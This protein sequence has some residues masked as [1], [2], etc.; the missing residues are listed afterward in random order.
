MAQDRGQ[1]L[2]QAAGA[3]GGMADTRAV[4]AEAI[5]HRRAA[6]VG[7]PLR[8]PGYGPR[9]DQV[10]P[11]QLLGDE[12]GIAHVPADGA[13]KSIAVDVVQADAAVGN[14]LGGGVVHEGNRFQLA[15]VAQRNVDRGRDQQVIGNA[16]HAARLRHAATA[17]LHRAPD[18]FT[19]VTNRRDQADSGDDDRL[20]FVARWRKSP[21]HFVAHR[22]LRIHGVRNYSVQPDAL[23]LLSP[24]SVD[25]S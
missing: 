7:H 17:A 22:G 24:K 10:V 5:R 9:F 21:R 4:Q 19:I 20:S 15:R 1:D 18:A 12:A 13:G 11:A 16:G 3:G 14:G 8:P 6:G 2:D 25:I 23:A